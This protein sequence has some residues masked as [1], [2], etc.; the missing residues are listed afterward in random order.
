MKDMC[1]ANFIFGTKIRRT[2]DGITLSQD[3]YAEKI[4]ERFKTSQSKCKNSGKLST[5]LD[6]ERRQG[7][8]TGGYAQVIGSFLYF[9]CT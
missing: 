9:N 7:N 4:L 1:L 8:I 5:A 6:Q 2:P 3:N